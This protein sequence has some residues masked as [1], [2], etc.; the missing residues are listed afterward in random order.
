MVTRRLALAAVL[1]II[2]APALAAADTP[3]AFLT[4]I[5]SRITAGDGTTG[6]APFTDRAGRSRVFVAD[7]ARIWDKADADA[8]K[9]GEI[10]PIEF[11]P[12]TDS[13]DPLVRRFTVRTLEATAERALS[14]VS[15]FRDRKSKAGEKP[16]T[17]LDFTLKR[18]AGGW[19][20]ED[21]ARKG[22]E[23]PWTLAEIFAPYR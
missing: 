14:R 12:F 21:I 22:G 17:V 7:L 23:M 13:Q 6:G 3:E 15:L 10:G 2:A 9:N 11:D 19:R 1:A 20:I 18:E 16:E 8:E 5:Y 4:A